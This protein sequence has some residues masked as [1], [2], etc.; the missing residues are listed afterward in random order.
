M[1]IR[2]LCE[3][4]PCIG[5]GALTSFVLGGTWGWRIAEIER[6]ELLYT[7]AVRHPSNSSAIQLALQNLHDSTTSSLTLN[8]MTCVPLVISLCFFSASVRMMMVWVQGERE[9]TL[10]L[11]KEF[12]KTALLGGVV[13]LG[14][15]TAIAFLGFTGSQL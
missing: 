1:H 12:Y 4:R 5:F 11:E 10:F 8:S 6:I 7:L 9:R 13:T 3:N 2:A 15:A 14:G